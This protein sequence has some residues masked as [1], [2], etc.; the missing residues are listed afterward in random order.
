MTCSSRKE[1][2]PLAGLAVLFS[3][4]YKN[5]RVKSWLAFTYQPQPKAS[6]LQL[7]ELNSEFDL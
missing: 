5:D 3:S 4:A 6:T 1:P 7:R 2:S